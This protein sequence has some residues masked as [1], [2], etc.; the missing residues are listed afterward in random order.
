[1][2]EKLRKIGIVAVALLVLAV[3]YYAIQ[4]YINW[5]D[6]GASV[7]TVPWLPDIATN[8]SFTRTNNWRIFEFDISELDFRN[9]AQQYDL[10]EIA[11]PFYIERYNY[12][13]NRGV[14]GSESELNTPPD[15]DPATV[16]IINAGLKCREWTANR[17]GFSVGYDRKT[18]R[19]YFHAQDR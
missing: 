4:K 1:M 2:I 8:I 5:R 6:T 18:G 14:G 7:K 3:G 19:A 9:W 16:A 11:E 12:S 15:F 13:G 17:G 10:V